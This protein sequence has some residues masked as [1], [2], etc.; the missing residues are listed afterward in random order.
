MTLLF[1]PTKSTA[2]IHLIRFFYLIHLIQI[3]CQVF[4]SCQ[5]KIPF[6]NW[7]WDTWKGI[8]LLENQGRETRVFAFGPLCW[9]TPSS[10]P[11]PYPP[12]S[13]QS[14]RSRGYFQSILR[15]MSQSHAGR[16]WSVVQ[17]SPPRD[18]T[19]LDLKP[20]LCPHSV[21]ARDQ[22]AHHDCQPHPLRNLSDSVWAMKVQGSQDMLRMGCLKNL[23]PGG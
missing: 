17:I 2:H 14:Q 8:D 4:P 1:H 19:S 22:R 15:K 7:W 23:G 3:S 11:P 21:R 10:L 12:F 5:K 20:F 13:K 6:S 16:T 18:P 9:N